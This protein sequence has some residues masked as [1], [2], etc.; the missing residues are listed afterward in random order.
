MYPLYLFTMMKGGDYS[1]R[2]VI[3]PLIR[4][5]FIQKEEVSYEENRFYKTIACYIGGGIFY[6]RNRY[7]GRRRSSKC[8]QRF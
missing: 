4:R 6:N 1:R 7:D 5:V 3:F 2:Q 8:A